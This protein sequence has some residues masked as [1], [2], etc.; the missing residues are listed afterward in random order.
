MNSNKHILRIVLVVESI[1]AVNNMLH[2]CE[3]DGRQIPPERN[4]V[5]EHH[6]ALGH[7]VEIRF[8]LPS[9]R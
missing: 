4:V 5:W 7:F 2:L 1:I 6:V 9:R 8:N 3:Y